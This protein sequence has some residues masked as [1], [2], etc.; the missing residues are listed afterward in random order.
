M[1]Y[2]PLPSSRRRR[3][4][5]GDLSPPLHDTTPT[6]LRSPGR[7]T[8]LEQRGLC[9]R[10][11]GGG[12][13][14][15]SLFSV[16]QRPWGYSRL[17]AAVSPDGAPSSTT[18][19]SGSGRGAPG[20]RGLSKALRRDPGGV[21]AEGGGKGGGSLKRGGF[22]ALIAAALVTV[23]RLGNSS[24]CCPPFFARP[25]PLHAWPPAPAVITLLVASSSLALSNRAILVDKL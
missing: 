3:V 6:G 13:C 18:L 20:H 11:L 25:H 17:C 8:E 14:S 23:Q 1:G 7:G 5:C 9:S 12:S 2:L 16:P 21:G 4:T 15:G 19:E 22:R 10:L 24:F